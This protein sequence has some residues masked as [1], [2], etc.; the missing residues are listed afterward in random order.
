MA[1]S[2]SI[3]PWV[4]K[5]QFGPSGWTEAFDEKP[6]KTVAQE[7]AL[8]PAELQTL[9]A[10]RNSFPELPLVNYTTQY[11]LGCFEG[12]KAYPQADGSM[13]LFRPDRNGA[14][15]E[16]SMV[17]LMMPGYPQDKFVEASRGVVSRNA[18]LGFRPTFDPAWEKDLFQDATAVY[19]R[20]F[21]YAEP[22]IG[23][24]LSAT[25]W[26]VIIGTPVSGYFKEGTTAAVTTDRVRAT[27]KGTGWIKC[28]AN[29]VIPILVKKQAEAE[30][31]MEAV[32]LDAKT[33]KYVEE[34]S[35]CNFFVVLKNGTLVT[36]ELGDTI[37]PG[38]TR[39]SVLTLAKDLGIKT[40]ERKLEIK[41][42]LD[43]GVECFVT[44]TA[45]GVTY[46]GSLTHLKRTTVFNG[47]KMGDVSRELQ[48]NLK[49]IQYGVLPDKH[50]W[51]TPV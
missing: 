13:K 25:P 6:H 38:I 44:G 37:L 49:G 27:P 42:V 33:Q 32:F 46:L 48:R 8:S 1:F 11:G 21:T 4:Y 41:E 16:K 18:A 9:L 14:R 3:Y 2:L 39:D 10:Q 15:M 36:P 7:D 29:Y 19:L 30:G 47:G 24:G 45:A 28:D 51:M 23:L 12:L 22:A 34:G 17:G 20:P 50:H 31:Y 26:V 35:S 40:E 5:A 43:K